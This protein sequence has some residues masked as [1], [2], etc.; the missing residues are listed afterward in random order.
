MTFTPLILAGGKSTRMRSPKHLL[1]MPDGRPLYQHQIDLLAR[2][3]PDAP[4]I[5]ISLAQD[6]ILDDYLQ[7]LLPTTTGE[8]PNSPTST[9]PPAPPSSTP[10]HNHNNPNNRNNHTT[11]QTTT[12]KKVIIISDPAP[13]Q[14]SPSASSNGPATGLL[15]AHHAHPAKSFLVIACDHPFL[16]VAALQQLCCAYRPPVTCFRNGEGFCEPLV[17]VWSPLALGGLET[18]M[19]GGKGK[20]V[21]PSRVVREL[22]GRVVGVD[23]VGAGGGEEGEG[24]GD[25]GLEVLVGVNTREEWE[26]ALTVLRK[27]AVLVEQGGC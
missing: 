22:G 2:A 24:E 14:P 25:G 3:C 6:S 21:G 1:P 12:P 10:N 15:A 9:S 7:S 11:P 19:G 26:A 16:T 13:P 4:A 17:G 5:Y 8:P 27:R 20:G 23:D 18:R